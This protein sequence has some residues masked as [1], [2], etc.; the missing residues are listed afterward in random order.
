MVRW[1]GLV[2]HLRSLRDVELYESW[3]LEKACVDGTYRSS[4]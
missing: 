4:S 3:N 1:G 2:G